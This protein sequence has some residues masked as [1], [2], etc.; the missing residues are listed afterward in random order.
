[1]AS[2]I[3]QTQT[4]AGLKKILV[5]SGYTDD[6]IQGAVAGVRSE[7]LKNVSAEMRKASLDVIVDS[8]SRVWVLVIAAGSLYT[9]CSLFLSK[10]RFISPKT[11]STS[12]EQTR[13]VN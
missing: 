4:F 2:A 7:V 10:T 9:I 6:E 13:G 1:M 11:K 8:I 12:S 3:F 5:G